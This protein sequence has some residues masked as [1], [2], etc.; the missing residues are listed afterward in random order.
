MRIETVISGVS[1][2]LVGKFNPAIFTPAWFALH[3]LLPAGVA[4]NAALQVAH[5]QITAFKTDW[6]HFE[7][8]LDVC[9]F[10]TVQAPHIR[11]ADLAIRTFR[12]HL[13][14]TPL[15]ALGINRDV[16]FRVGEAAERDRI[17]R[18]LV[19]VEPWGPWR[20]ELELDGEHSGM[21]SVTMSQLRP[22]ERPDGGGIN[23]K[24]E[25]SKRIKERRLGVYVNVNDH[26]DAVPDSPDAN[27][28]LMQLLQD[29]FEN[30][31]Q[32]SANIIDH[33]MSL[34]TPQES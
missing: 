11:V 25:P 1:I 16:H 29:N 28:R 14:H 9:K 27:A 8:T 13:N 5:Q 6:L 17:G 26:Y 18:T 10:E 32:R 33:I 30:S 34:A 24:V 4:E 3:D 15:T 21:T 31:I 7:V 20:D 22:A 23:I 19:P 2:V 12:E